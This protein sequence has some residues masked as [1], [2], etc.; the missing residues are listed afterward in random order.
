MVAPVHCGRKKRGYGFLALQGILP[1]S[2]LL[3]SNCLLYVRFCAGV[4]P[5][6]SASGHPSSFRRKSSALRLTADQFP[7]LVSCPASHKAVL[8]PPPRPVRLV[9]L[10]LGVGGGAKETAPPAMVWSPLTRR[11]ASPG[12]A[13]LRRHSSSLFNS[14]VARL[15]VCYPPPPLPP[16]I[17]TNWVVTNPLVTTLS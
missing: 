16:F 10:G 15:S 8:H 1:V 9:V 6:P 4:R 12:L 11:Q 14:C 13:C 2:S 3:S 17:V 7:L 5:L